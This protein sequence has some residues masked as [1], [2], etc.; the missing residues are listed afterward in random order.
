M[1]SV[2]RLSLTNQLTILATKF[3][4]VGQRGTR[5]IYQHIYNVNLP[6]CAIPAKGVCGPTQEPFT[7][8]WAKFF[9]YSTSIHLDPETVGNNNDLE[10]KHQH[11]SH[12]VPVACL[13]AEAY[14]TAPTRHPAPTPQQVAPKAGCWIA[15][16]TGI[17][18]GRGDE[19]CLDMISRLGMP[20]V[21]EVVISPCCKDKFNASRP[22]NDSTFADYA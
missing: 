9:G 21:N 13:V 5:P 14:R 4:L 19:R 7:L 2:A 3:F 12:G 20:L 22:R 8:Q 16:T 11:V 17:E 15:S 18:P 10:Q 1:L 6:G